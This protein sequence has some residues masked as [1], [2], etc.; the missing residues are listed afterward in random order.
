M[1]VFAGVGLVSRL[2]YLFTHNKDK[3]KEVKTTEEE[4]TKLREVTTP[5]TTRQTQKN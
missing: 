5:V 4:K 2:I 3:T 1:M